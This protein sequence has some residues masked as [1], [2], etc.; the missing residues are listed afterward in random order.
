VN[1]VDKP[2]KII[3]IILNEPEKQK[4]IALTEDVELVAPEMI[5]FEIGN[6]LSR[7]YKKHRLT[8]EQIVKAY[9]LYKALPLRIV[10]VDMINALR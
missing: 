9:T 4:I 1:S 3:Y 8:G 5:A 2:V 7:M 6:A 10:K